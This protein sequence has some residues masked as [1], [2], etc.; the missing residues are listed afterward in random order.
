MRGSECG[1]QSAGVRVRGSE[2][3]GQSAGVVG[4][5]TADQCNASVVVI[6]LI[7]LLLMQRNG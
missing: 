2:C 6:I 7:G 5:H 3:R 4:G 1:G